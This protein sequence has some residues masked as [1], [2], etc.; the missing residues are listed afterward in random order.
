MAGIFNWFSGSGANTA[1]M[2]AADRLKALQSDYAASAAINQ[3]MG[4]ITGGVGLV[5]NLATMPLAYKTSKNNL[6][7]QNQQIANNAATMAHKASYNS[8]VTNG[9]NNAANQPRVG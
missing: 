1:G 2:S 6:A 5:N 4:T 8:A 7:L 3:D 9:F